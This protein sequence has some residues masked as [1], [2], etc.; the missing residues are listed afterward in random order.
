MVNGGVCTRASGEGGCQIE[1]GGRAGRGSVRDGERA[2][3]SLTGKN[4]KRED[5][6]CAT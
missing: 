6:D 2:G 4:E 1:G 5:C 3:F